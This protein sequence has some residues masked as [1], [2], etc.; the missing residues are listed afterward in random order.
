MMAGMTAPHARGS[1]AL[2]VVT[3]AVALVGVALTLLAWGDIILADA[4]ANVASGLAGAAYAAIGALIVRRTGNLI[5]WL[6]QG[7]GLGL[8]LLAATGAY[9]VAGL[10]TYP[11]SLPAA[12]DV[13]AVAQS[14]F[15]P[16][17]VAMAFLLFFF[18][19]GTLRSPRWRPIVAVGVLATALTA[20]GVLVNPVRLNLPA[21]GG[22]YHVPN[23][24]GIHSVAGLISTVLVGTT[25]VIV[26]SIA[27]S[28]AA[29]VV[30]YRAGSREL[31]EQI[32]WVGF[33][34]AL[35]LLCQVVAAIGLITCGC[36][37][38]PVATVAFTVI[39]FLVFLG[40]PMALAVA[41]LKYRL[42]EIDVVINKAVVYGVLAVFITGV[43]LTVVVAAGSLT[44]YASNP[45]LSG[46]AA[47]IVAVAFQPVRRGTQRL[48]N[49]L[50]YG[51]RATPYEVLAQLGDRL[52]GEYAADDVL[53]RIAAALAGGI[54]ADRVVVW[55]DSGGE[56]RPAA[57]W[58]RGARAAPI[59]ASAAEVTATEDGLRSFPVRH[60]GEVLGAIGVHKPPSDPLT[61]ADDKL[62]R[63]LAAEAG[64]VLR[65]VRLI[66]DLRASRRRLVTAQDEERRRL[67]RNIHDGAQQQL[68]AL[69]IKARLAEQMIDRDPAKARDL[70]AQIGTETTGTLEDLRDLARGIYPPL[71]ADKGL[72]AA[73]EAQGRKAAVPVAVKADGVGRLDRD[74]EAGVYFCV[75][76][77][78][79]NV[80]KYAGAS[81][82]DVRLWWQDGEVV[83]EVSD[84]GVGF[85]RAARGYGTGLRGM[86]DRLEALGGTLEVQSAPGA[87]TKILGRVPAAR[88]QHE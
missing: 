82:V 6:L 7:I 5:G 86:A 49:R 69:T 31:R 17:A 45:V 43:Y 67:E 88:V 64:L 42:Y 39:V 1:N 40:M 14:I 62:V 15:G 76:E 61:P 66:E 80:A 52:A 79:N 34:A 29:L 33:V 20:I 36:D 74:V 11:G 23:P 3:A 4:L 18:P 77:A 75:L 8:A 47:A 19:T 9:A 10:A 53:D 54:G 58:P 83:F 24:L 41:I 56:L 60:Q 85:D 30:R 87:G 46:I 16:T 38:S 55:L 28:F 32:K 48:A 25:W 81:H 27:S 50:I 63:D 68:V 35:V 59:A 65:N 26:I 37:N 22:A 57:V 73:L 78:L 70:V 51:E 84:D 44:G 2:L 21:P 12:G 71:L 13:G 72:A